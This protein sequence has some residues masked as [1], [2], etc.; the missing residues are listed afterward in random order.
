MYSKEIVL[1]LKHSIDKDIFHIADL[2]SR[3]EVNHSD[4]YSLIVVSLQI[5]NKH[6]REVIFPSLPSW[7][8]KPLIF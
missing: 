5:I 3:E 2:D 6:L 1:P 7:Y 8:I 4:F